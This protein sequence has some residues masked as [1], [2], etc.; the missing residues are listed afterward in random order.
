MTQISRLKFEELYQFHFPDNSTGEIK[1][2]DIRVVFDDLADSVLWH[3]EATSGPPGASAYDL[4]VVHGFKGSVDDWLAT[5]VGPAG[6]PGPAGP[7]GADGAVGPAGPAGPEGPQGATGA[8]GPAGAQGVAGPEGPQGP[9][10]PAGPQGPSGADG[11]AVAAVRAIAVQNYDVSAA[12]DGA[13]LTFG[14][15]DGSTVKLPDDAT[16]PM[17]VGAIVHALQTGDG[18]VTIE[19]ATGVTL[20]RYEGLIPQT[21]RRNGVVSALKI[22]A[23]RWRVFGDLQPAPG[24]VLYANG[25]AVGSVRATAQTAEALTLTDAGGVVELTA[26]EAI[27]MTLP[28]DATAAIPEGAV[29]HVVQ[30]GAGAVTFM[31]ETGAKALVCCERSPKISGKDGVVRAIKTAPNTWRLTGDLADIH[32]FS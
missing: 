1:P 10:G 6:P 12:D 7:A 15:A 16:E 14:A 29:V 19:T 22:G 18:P 4:A 31:A 8:T 13:V 28:T 21:S 3:D 26:A 9:V 17:R 30:A 25:G 27:V 5:L 32:A 2:E 24:V 23:N 20:N 11:R